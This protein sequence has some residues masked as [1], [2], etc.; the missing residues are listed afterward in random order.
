MPSSDAGTSVPDNSDTMSTSSTVSEMPNVPIPPKEI[1]HLAPVSPEHPTI[2][3]LPPLLGQVQD[4]AAQTPNLIV[5]DTI[6]RMLASVESRIS[7]G[8]ILPPSLQALVQAARR[9]HVVLAKQESRLAHTMVLSTLQRKM[10]VPPAAAACG[11]VVLCCIYLQDLMR[12]Q[13]HWVST[14]IGVL[15]PIW[16]SIRAIENPRE[17]DDERWLTYWSVYGLLT[18]LDHRAGWIQKRLKTYHVPK[19]VLLI[20]LARYNG[21]LT[22]YRHILRPLMHET[23]K[24]MLERGWITTTAT[25]TTSEKPTTNGSD[26]YAPNVPY[27]IQ[28]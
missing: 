19:I 1:Q 18:M 14:C 27:V 23:R 12:K 17:D 8:T 6:A 25:T 2:A 20:W 11:I 4:P 22:V 21:S 28:S 10:G 5:S 9:L 24:T 15:Y 16:C 3:T 13:P 26:D 7:T